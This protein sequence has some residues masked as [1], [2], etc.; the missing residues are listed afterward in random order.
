ML[1]ECSYLLSIFPGSALRQYTKAFVLP[2]IVEQ[3]YA[4]YLSPHGLMSQSPFA[5][6]LAEILRARQ[7]GD[8]RAEKHIPELMSFRSMRNN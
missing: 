1:P 5:Q 3:L 4:R 7:E 8:I 2:E 6:C